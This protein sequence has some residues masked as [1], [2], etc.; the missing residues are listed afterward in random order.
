[1]NF[2]GNR[3]KDGNHECDPII[4]DIARSFSC[5]SDRSEGH[6]VQ[7]KILNNV[8]R[9]KKKKID[10]PLFGY[11]YALPGGKRKNCRHPKDYGEPKTCCSKKFLHTIFFCET[12]NAFR[13]FHTIISAR[14]ASPIPIERRGMTIGSTRLN[15]AALGVASVF[16]VPRI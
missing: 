2:I 13:F 10:H 16:T 6:Y 15:P 5:I 12:A 9:L 14:I 3:I 8:K 7:S 4:P 1:M 11:L